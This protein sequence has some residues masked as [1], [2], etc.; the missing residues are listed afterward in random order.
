[1]SSVFILPEVLRRAL[2]SLNRP[3]WPLLSLL[4]FQQIP[5]KFFITVFGIE[6]Q[7]TP[8]PLQFH[9]LTEWAHALWMLKLMD[10]GYII[11]DYSSSISEA[12]MIKKSIKMP[13]RLWWI[14]TITI[15]TT[16]MGLE[17]TCICICTGLAHVFTHAASQNRVLVLNSEGQRQCRWH[18]IAYKPNTQGNANTGLKYA[19]IARSMLARNEY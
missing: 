11:V 4:R 3:Q 1:M 12:Q 5:K 15:N 9:W 8:P 14:C 6:G 16:A 17:Y 2:R 19:T 18:F 13:S 10:I 7:S